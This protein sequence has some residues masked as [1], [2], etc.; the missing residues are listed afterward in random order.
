MF[1]EKFQPMPLIHSDQLFNRLHSD[2]IIL[3]KCL[4]SVF[5]NSFHKHFEFCCEKFLFWFNVFS[6]ILECVVYELNELE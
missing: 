4:V 3:F 5:F 6:V 2:L 1:S